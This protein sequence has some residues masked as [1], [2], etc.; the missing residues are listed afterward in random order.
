MGNINRLYLDMDGV[1]VDFDSRVE[2]FGCRKFA[3]KSPS[4]IDWDIPRRI[5]PDFWANMKWMAGADAFFA[6]CRELCNATGIEMGILTAIEMPAGVKGKTLWT[7]WNTDID[8]EHLI[9]VRHGEDKAKFARPDRLLVDDTDKNVDGF[10]AAGGQAI[11]YKDPKSA[12]AE[13]MRR[14]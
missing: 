6:A 10:I 8:N 2:E 5:G 11:L 14:I 1:L 13:I 12:L 3:G 7:H 4:A 9:I